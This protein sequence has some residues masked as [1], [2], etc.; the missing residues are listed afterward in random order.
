MWWIR[1]ACGNHRSTAKT[2]RERHETTN[3]RVLVCSIKNL[4]VRCV[5]CLTCLSIGFERYQ[6]GRRQDG[7]GEFPRVGFDVAEFPVNVLSQ[8]CQFVLALRINDP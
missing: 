2:L 1:F 3:L 7:V 6:M 8:R 4:L 5:D